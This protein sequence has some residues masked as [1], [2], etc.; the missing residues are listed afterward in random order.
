MRNNCM[1]VRQGALGQVKELHGAERAGHLLTSPWGGV[2]GKVRGAWTIEALLA[3]SDQVVGVLLLQVPAHL[4][5]PGLHST[6]GTLLL[7]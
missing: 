6:P 3:H 2:V 1:G 7:Y 5:N 4:L